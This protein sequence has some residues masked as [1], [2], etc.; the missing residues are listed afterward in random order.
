[1]STLHIFAKPASHYI[2]H[3]LEKRISKDDS[4]I[5]VSD[6]C[7]STEQFKQLSNQLYILKE[8]AF[9]RNTTFNEND[10]A[11]D[12]TAFVDLTLNTDNTISW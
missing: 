5:L 3:E 12:Y 8:D 2:G 9:A 1:M 6:A 4:V 11:I 7:Y 10:A